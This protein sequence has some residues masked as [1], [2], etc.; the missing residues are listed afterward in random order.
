MCWAA[1]QGSCQHPSDNGDIPLSPTSFPGGSSLP[2]PYPQGRPRKLPGLQQRGCPVLLYLLAPQRLQWRVTVLRASQEVR[3]VSLSLW[4]SEVTGIWQRGKRKLP[5]A[6][7]ELRL[8]AGTQTVLAAQIC[9][10]CDFPGQFLLQDTR[11]G[12]ISQYIQV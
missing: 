11:W 3:A 2:G 1:G 12:W 10:R 8:A 7:S 4:G 5:V 9:R 6:A